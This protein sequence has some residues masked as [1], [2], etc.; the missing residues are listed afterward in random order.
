M[1]YSKYIHILH[2]LNQCPGSKEMTEDESNDRLNYI[3]EYLNNNWNAPSTTIE[4][5]R[6][7]GLGKL[8]RDFTAEEK[9]QFLKSKELF[10]MEDSMLSEKLEQLPPYFD[11]YLFP[12]AVFRYIT[13]IEKWK[14]SHMK[15]PAFVEFAKRNFY[16]IFGE[17][18]PSNAGPV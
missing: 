4:Y 7:Y 11:E 18:R 8:G 5:D 16:Q 14:V 6:Q 12:V 1:K 3:L 17:G 15:C 9:E 13:R 10:Q 2:Y